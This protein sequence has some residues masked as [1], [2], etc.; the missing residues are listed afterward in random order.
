M[1]KQQNYQKLKKVWYKKLLK[2]GFVDIETKSGHL[3]GGSSNWKFNSK[4]ESAYSQS[5]KQEYYYLANEL[6]N[7][8]TFDSDLHKAIWAYHAEGIS[9][10]DIANIL[11]KLPIKKSFNN[12]TS[13]WLIV[14]KYKDIIKKRAK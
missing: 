7:T 11:K 8:H 10:R 1:P 4:H 9:V 14:K 2:S 12:Y 3:K 13:V 6:L 5:A